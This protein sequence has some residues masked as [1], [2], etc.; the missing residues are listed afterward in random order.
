MSNT[1]DDFL[2]LLHGENR[3]FRR[4]IP[5]EWIER[6]DLYINFCFE[7]VKAFVEDELKDGGEE[8]HH[9]KHV[10]WARNWYEYI[11]ETRPSLI[12]LQ[13]SKE[14]QD[15]YQEW[16]DLSEK[17]SKTDKTFARELANCYNQIWI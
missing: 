10:K 15:F 13:E 14:S 6:D 4:I 8:N 2:S 12:E 3:R 11:T 16:L 1:I 9:P 5:R 7:L 17:I